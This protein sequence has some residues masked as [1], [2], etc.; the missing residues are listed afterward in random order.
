MILFRGSFQKENQKDL[1]TK[2]IETKILRRREKLKKKWIQNSRLILISMKKKKDFQS[3][4]EI[5]KVNLR[6][7]KKK[8]MFQ[9]EFETLFGIEIE[10]QIQSILLS[11]F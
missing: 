4:N 5:Q 8:L 9:R 2:M 3:K 10:N 1:S 7:L 11:Q 6:V